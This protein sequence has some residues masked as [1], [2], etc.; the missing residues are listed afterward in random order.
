MLNKP[1]NT[2]V[3]GFWQK[4]KPIVLYGL[5]LA[6]LLV[7]LKWIEYRYWIHDFSLETYLGLVAVFFSILGVWAGLKWT[8]PNAPAIVNPS[9]DKPA[10][11]EQVM[12]KHNISPREYEVLCLIAEGLSNQEIAGRLF[13][14]LNT[15]KTHSSNLFLKLDV[16]RRTQAVQRAQELGLL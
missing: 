1:M 12:K 4:N 9:R 11:V 10:N 6:V 14:S 3:S 8:K 16:K 15:I 2:Q 13:V 7:V 5:V